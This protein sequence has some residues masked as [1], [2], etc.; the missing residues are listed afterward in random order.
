MNRPIT[1]T[2][3]EN[4]SKKLPKKKSA[5]ADGFAGKF[6]QTSKQELA[7]ILLKFFLKI[8][9]TGIPPSSIYEVTITLISKP[10]K[11]TRK[12]KITSQYH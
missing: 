2:E 4:V 8:A 11:D 10:H 3:I 1:G 5:G 7:P 6:Y 12:K 9:E